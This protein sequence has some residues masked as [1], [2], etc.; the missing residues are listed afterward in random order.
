MK[1]EYQHN[2]GVRNREDYVKACMLTHAHLVKAL[3]DECKPGEFEQFD[4]SSFDNQYSMP[5]L[6]MSDKQLAGLR[7]QIT[8]VGT[9]KAASF[10]VGFAFENGTKGKV[11]ATLSEIKN[12]SNPDNDG[13]YLNLSLNASSDVSAI[14][15]VIIEQLQH[16]DRKDID[17]PEKL[18][19][20]TK[21]V[22]ASAVA[23][24]VAEAVI[25]GF[26]IA[27]SVGATVE[28]NLLNLT[29]WLCNMRA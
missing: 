17:D 19:T 27:G 2:R 6:P 7:K 14:M 20:A 5:R 23:G 18:A 25:P 11:N 8:K 26:D 29:G 13:V 9:A 1:H 12:N 10:D 4:L 22:I 21:E 3:K 16:L 15:P 28:L 24:G